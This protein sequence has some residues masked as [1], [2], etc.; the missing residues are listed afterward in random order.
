M[1]RRASGDMPRVCVV[2]PS[3]NARVRI[4]GRAHWLGKCPDGKVTAEQQARAARLW[5]EH[6]SGI[7]PTGEQTVEVVVAPQ[8]STQTTLIPQQ[9]AALST[10]AI[11]VAQLGLRY[12]DFCQTYYRTPEGKVTSSVAGVEMALRALFPFSDTPAATFG[13]RALKTVREAL[14]RDGRPRV[15]C[16]R[17]V[18]TIRRMFKWAASEELVSAEAWHSLETVAALQKG[19]T[20]APEIEP[21][22][23]VPESVVAET[24]PHLPPVI[25]AM[26]WLQRWTGARP[27]EVCLL[28]PSDIDR[29]GE[30]WV[31]RPEHHKLSWREDSLPRQITIGSEGQKVLMPFLLRAASTYCFSPADAERQ[32]LQARRE[33]RKTPLYES[34]VTHMKRKRKGRGAKRRPGERYTTASYR[35]AI[36]RAVESAN[37]A[38]D[39]KGIEE[40]LPNWSPNQLRHLRAGE[41]EEQFGIEA[42]SAILGHS[43]IR[44]TEIYARRKLQIATAV[45][46]QIG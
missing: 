44:T 46:R 25:A 2:R 3:M 32:R 19:R 23:E 1:G 7:V 12:L 17:V 40:R 13:P 28:R 35:R 31:Y 22:D 5:H 18:K 21:V 26:V 24:L 27:G 34:H 33:E 8:A 4:G 38:R 15:T 11:S 6:L 39:A 14:V 45:T 10:G 42:A 37:D 30:V 43:N 29:S 9:T 20:D 36:T 16:N 41:V